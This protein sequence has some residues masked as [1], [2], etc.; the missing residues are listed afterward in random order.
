MNKKVFP[1]ELAYIAG[2]V[3]LALG[4]ALME[5][6]D[7]GIS[8]VV[9]PAY[10]IHLKLV[11][12]LPFWS[13]G[14]SE[15]AFQAVLIL[16]LSLILRRFRRSFLLSFATAV[17]YGTLLDIAMKPA[18]W[19]PADTLP[20]RIVWFALGTAVCALG[21]ALLFNTYLTPEAYELFVKEIAQ[22]TGKGLGFVKTVYD[23]ASCLTGT[24]LSFAFFGFMHFEGVKWGTL[25]C[26]LVNGPLIGLISKGL[27]R[28]FEFRDALPWRRFFEETR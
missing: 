1:S 26:A 22:K 19:L 18:A 12:V 21:V 11:T 15:Y 2:L 16:L 9:A 6:S 7:L 4:T 13:F 23:I 20:L 8:M 10:V 14:V 28:A 5:R 24:A 25:V 3:I 17:L 27:S